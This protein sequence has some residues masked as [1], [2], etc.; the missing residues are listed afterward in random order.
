MARSLRSPNRH[1]DFGEPCGKPFHEVAAIDGIV[2]VKGLAPDAVRLRQ[3]GDEFGRGG[4]QVG[5]RIG[6][7]PVFARRNMSVRP[8]VTGLVAHDHRLMTIM[9][10]MNDAQLGVAYHD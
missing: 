9:A 1:A 7:R 6:D 10:G 5:E 8:V 2:V 3:Q 4:E